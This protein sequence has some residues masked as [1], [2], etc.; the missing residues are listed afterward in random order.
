MIFKKPGSFC[1]IVLSVLLVGAAS[2]Q[3]QDPEAEPQDPP[4]AP[5]ED[6]QTQGEQAEPEAQEQPAP[7]K[8]V[9][10]AA[11]LRAA[12]V[13]DEYCADVAAGKATESAQAL[14]AVGPVL[15]EVS[16]AHDASGAPYLLYWRGRLNLCLDREGRA[17][18]DLFLFIEAAGDDPAYRTQVQ[19]ARSL[20]RRASRAK[21][22]TGA[23]IHT[24]GAAVAGGALLGVGAALGGLSAWQWRE[25]S[26][27]HED[28]V[29][30]GIPWS[31]SEQLLND[32]QAA[33][34]RSQVL[35]GVAVGS[36]VGG[37]VSFV[38]STVKPRAATGS[39]SSATLMPLP[40]GGVAVTMGTQW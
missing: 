25:A 15:A 27:R 33:Q 11:A 8:D 32:S 39:L 23:L 9:D 2:G 30:G 36:S 19:L 14:S 12:Q 4:A 28:Y 17:E 10:A 31:Q 21:A 35:L 37:L 18:E 26:S 24:P 20:L 6:E 1:S 38:L 40:G 34:T 5:S 3:A 22:S 16:A 7:S 13:L 29:N